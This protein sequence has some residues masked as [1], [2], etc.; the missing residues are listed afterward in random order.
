MKKL[1]VKIKMIGLLDIIAFTKL[2]PIRKKKFS[3]GSNMPLN[4]SPYV[5]NLAKML[6]PVKQTLSV[7]EIKNE[8]EGVK[9]FILTAQ[10]PERPAY[11]RA[12]QYLSI[13][14]EIDGSKITRPYSISSSPKDAL[15]GFY[16]VTMKRN[17]SGFYTKWAFDNIKEGSEIN[18]SG[19][20]GNF[21]YEPLRDGKTVLGICGGSGVTPFRSMAKAVAEGT[22]NFNLILL[23]GSCKECDIL[24]KKDFTDFETMS[25]GKVKVVHI[26]SDEKKKGYE[27][28]FITAEIIKKYA[29]SSEKYSIFICGPQ[30]MYNFVEKEIKKLKI[31]EKFIRRELFGEIKKIETVKGYDKK[32]SQRLSN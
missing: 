4:P 18:A 15:K 20:E 9:I 30:V 1:N 8:A 2:V 29:P 14:S 13:I 12:G 16:S 6:H 24:F 23:Y 28:G 11:F 5:N 32:I 3:E 21:Y 27:E 17:E 31:E 22:E 10:E 26:L 25:E 7:K 19:P